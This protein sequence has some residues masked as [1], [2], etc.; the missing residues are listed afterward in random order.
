FARRVRRWLHSLVGSYNGFLRFFLAIHPADVHL[1]ETEGTIET[2]RRLVALQRLHL[3]ELEELILQIPQDL[4]DQELGETLP[5]HLLADL[6]VTDADGVLVPAVAET[7]HLPDEGPRRDL[8]AGL[9]VEEE[10]QRLDQPEN[11]ILPPGHAALAGTD[12][13]VETRT[14][15]REASVGHLE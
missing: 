12:A 7:L 6:Q 9:L 4:A 2:Q 1:L 5:A 11:A 3:H 8:A 14:V 10:F 13:Q 15:G